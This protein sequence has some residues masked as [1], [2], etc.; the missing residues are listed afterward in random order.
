MTRRASRRRGGNYE[1]WTAKYNC[2]GVKRVNPDSIG[3]Y[4]VGFGLTPFA[5]LTIMALGCKAL[6]AGTMHG[7]LIQVTEDRFARDADEL[8]R[9]FLEQVEASHL[10]RIRCLS[11]GQVLHWQGD[12]V[13]NVFVVS[14][15]SL[16]EYTLLPDGRAYAYR[17]LGAGGL[18][19]ATAYLLGQDHDTITQALDAVEVIA[20]QLSEFD[21]LL[22]GNPRFSS[23]LTRKLAQSVQSS[24]DKAR[25]L[26]FLDVQQ[27]LDGSRRERGQSPAAARS[28]G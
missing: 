15:G 18:A 1:H 7:N 9:A 23:L 4:C 12:P 3:T 10:G 2:S 11:R 20:L 14:S 17:V 8:D 26:G 24:A 16:K 19:G 27:R 13:R 21:R 6:A 22:A 28:S 25:A 5:V